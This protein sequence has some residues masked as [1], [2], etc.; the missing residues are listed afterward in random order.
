MKKTILVITALIVSTT[1]YGQ[2]AVGRIT[3]LEGNPE[4]IRDGDLVV[5][6]LDFGFPVENFDSIQTDSA[7]VAELELDGATGI[8]ATIYVQE[9]TQ[10]TVNVSGLRQ[11]QE[12]TLDLVAGSIG[13]RVRELTGTSRLNVR[14]YGGNAGVRGT[15]FAVTAAVDGSVL[16]STEEGLVE[17]TGGSGQVL[18]AAP[19]EAVEVDHER[20]LIRNLKYQVAL[21]IFR[22]EWAAARLRNL[23]ENAPRILRYYGQRYLAARSRFI[24]AYQDLMRNRVVIDRWIEQSRRGITSEGEA[25]L[26]ER[27][28]LAEPLRELAILAFAF[29]QTRARLERLL[30]YVRDNLADIEFPGSITAADVSRTLRADN[31]VMRQRL[32]TVRQVMKLYALRNE[33]DTPFA[34]FDAWGVDREILG[35]PE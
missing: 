34:R 32:A 27:S 14:T 31:A 17:V 35:E 28:Q 24:A 2:T 3:Y 11:E 21:E 33:G 16:V 26:A 13:V 5:E 12:G 9:E 8:S 10:F 7:S 20:G 22:E 6:S 29:E 23:Q 18:F 1:L 30:P 25:L 4:V 19:G 15:T